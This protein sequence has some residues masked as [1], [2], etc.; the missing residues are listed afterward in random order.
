MFKY[1]RPDL[2]QE[3]GISNFDAWTDAFADIREVAEISARG[4]FRN[5]FQFKSFV[6]LPELITLFREFTDIKMQDDLDLPLPKHEVIKVE[7]DPHPLLAEVM[8]KVDDAWDAAIKDRTLFRLINIVLNAPQDMRL[9]M[10][11]AQNH[12]G[13]KVNKV[14]ENA[15]K[16]YKETDK[17][18]GTQLIFATT[19]ESSRTGFSLWDE[20]KAQ[21]VKEGIPEN[22][23]AFI[24]T[25]I[26][27]DQLEEIYRKINAGKI[28][29]AIGSFSKMGVRINVQERLFAIHELNAPYRPADIEQAEGRM[30]RQGNVTMEQISPYRSIVM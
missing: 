19:G 26:K 1:L 13:S 15:Y 23:I 10:A 22:E 3:A 30:I 18:K 5:K 25:G 28:R 7:C 17:E 2:L 6:N 11:G 20:I 16:I 29:V 21:L 12:K 27:E 14:T 9:V 24:K 8:K 4:E